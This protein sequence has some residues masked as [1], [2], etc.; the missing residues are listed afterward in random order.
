M[1][2]KLMGFRVEVDTGKS[3]ESMK[4]KMNYLKGICQK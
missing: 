1:N 4:G 3:A 2:A